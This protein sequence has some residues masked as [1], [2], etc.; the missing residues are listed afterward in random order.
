MMA[1]G[2]MNDIARIAIPLKPY[3]RNSAYFYAILRCLFWDRNIVDSQYDMHVDGKPVKTKDSGGH[4]ANTPIFVH[5]GT[6]MMPT[7]SSWT[8]GGVNTGLLTTTWRN[9]SF[10]L[11]ALREYEKKE[12]L[13][14]GTAYDD[15]CYWI[16][17]GKIRVEKKG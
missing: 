1:C 10:S 7:G 8:Y 14:I 13:G 16:R 12:T 2:I 6:G 11:K 5:W 17:G 9:E 3:L 15:T 4:A